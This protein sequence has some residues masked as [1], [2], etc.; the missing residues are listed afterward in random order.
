MTVRE[1]HGYFQCLSWV[2]D[3][4]KSEAC[5]GFASFVW[6]PFAFG[7]MLGEVLPCANTTGASTWLTLPSANTPPSSD[8]Q[9]LL[10]DKYQSPESAWLW[11]K[12]QEGVT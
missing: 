11:K 1:A 8:L 9:T 4:H 10:E 3:W 12:S 2:C 5:L 7:V 6:W